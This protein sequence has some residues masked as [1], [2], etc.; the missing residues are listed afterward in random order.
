MAKGK[1]EAHS[2][3]PPLSFSNFA[4]QTST[5]SGRVTYFGSMFGLGGPSTGMRGFGPVPFHPSQ[6]TRR[7]HP[8][9][10]PPF[11]S[12]V[13]GSHVRVVRAPS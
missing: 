8:P 10:R 5:R 1:V 6:T 2:L 3:P 13:A 7:H 11:R 4:A 12:R 9:N